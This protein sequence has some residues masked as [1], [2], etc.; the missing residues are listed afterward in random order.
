MTSSFPSSRAPVASCDDLL[1]AEIC[2]VLD[3]LADPFAK[4]SDKMHFFAR[5]LQRFSH[6]PV[7]GLYPL[8]RLLV[9]QL[10]RRRPPAQ[11]KQPLLARVYT[12]VFALPPAAAARLKLY[13]D[14]TAATASAVSGGMAVK[15]GDFASFVAASV[16]ERVGRRRATV[17]VKDLNRELDLVALAGSLA[18]KSAILQGLLPQLT[19]D[20]HK[21]CMRILM[22]EVKMGG[23][24]G[25]RLLTLL[26]AD[27]RKIINQCSDLK[28]TLDVIEEEKAEAAQAK[29]EGAEGDAPAGERASCLRLL[30]QPLRP[31]LAQTVRPVASDIGAVLFGE[32]GKVTKDSNRPSEEAR[33]ES[34]Q[35]STKSPVA[36][37]LYFIERKY[38]GER[39]LA[40]IDKTRTRWSQASVRLFTRRG[41]DYTSLYGGGG[42]H[43]YSAS[44][45]SASASSLSG[46]VGSRWAKRERSSSEEEARGQLDGAKRGKRERGEPGEAG[47][48]G[49]L[50]GLAAT[51]AEALRGSQAILD[52]ELLA[53]DDELATFLPF[54]TNK[55]VAAAETATCH[56]SYVVFDVLYYRNLEGDEYSLLNMKLQDRKSGGWFKLKPHLGSLPDTLDLIAV[57]AFFAEGSRRRDMR[58][59]HLIDHC[60]HFLLGVLEGKGGSDAKRVKSFCKIGTGFSLATLREIR[61]HLRPHCRRFQA[62]EPPPWFDACTGSASMRVD[63]TWPPSCS[64][65]MEVK[66]AE[67]SQGNEFDVGATLRFPVAVRPFRR[68]KAWHEA[69]S[70]QALHAFFALAE[71]CGGRLLSQPLSTADAEP[72]SPRGGP[73]ARERQGRVRPLYQHSEDSDGS[74]SDEALQSGSA[75]LPGAGAG[76]GEDGSVGFS[77]TKRR[78]NALPLSPFPLEG[79]SE[80]VPSRPSPLSRVRSA[81]SGFA[82]LALLAAFRAADTSLIQPSSSA[83]RGTHI[84]VLAGNEEA[85]PKASLEALVA[86]LGGKV[87]QTLS[88][89]VTHI[90][91]DRPSFRTRA[92]AAAVTKL[93]T[94]RQK[95]LSLAEKRKH[96]NSPSS[97]SCSP[98]SSTPAS[99][100]R[101][102]VHVAPV[103]HFRWILE[104]AERDA[105]VP[106]RPSLVIHGT[107][108]TARLFARRFDIFGDAFVE[109]EE[110]TARGEARL[111]ALLTHAV[112]EADKRKTETHGKETE[113]R[114][115]EETEGREQAEDEEIFGVC[116]TETNTLRRELEPFLRS[117]EGSQQP[118]EGAG[119]T[120]AT[121][122]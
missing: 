43:R 3:R 84:W 22:K 7:S 37:R 102:S 55:S 35:S 82:R 21:W 14:P 38:D 40:H 74:D 72:A 91:A 56:L 16:Q 36:S 49:G 62:A 59:V 53:W 20:E 109:D 75:D 60:S 9:P 47:E 12:Q 83:L 58:S 15:A 6:L 108:E 99:A 71:E 65:V 67:L 100:S 101:E 90:L 1:F 2:K 87:S 11:L 24:S 34:A 17:T 106:L 117:E 28:S 42:Q 8:F 18:E 70:E 116:E 80:S 32:G 4:A 85:F 44:A 19:V 66:G 115:R 52:G 25:E 73:A 95:K 26:H 121:L 88:P 46:S 113:R 51:L 41:R 114:T 57:G 89:S 92:V 98:A 64:F 111:S 30:F 97:S 79:L 48:T 27:A 104:C 45:S 33:S 76:A 119:K 39:L 13:K 63:V 68:D 110:P 81:S 112:D 93:A 120:V 86:H 61:D 94:E 105:A 103:V 118:R 122:E 78:P 50:R 29:R 69:M 54:G 23:V 5:Y 107:P 96:T 31:M 10:D 77:P